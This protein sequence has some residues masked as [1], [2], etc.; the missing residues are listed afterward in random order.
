MLGKLSCAGTMAIL[1]VYLALTTHRSLA[2]D[3][4]QGR[5]IAE[6]RCAPCHIV[7]PHAR[8]E[9]ANS[10]PFDVI[11]KKYGA[12][13]DMIAHAILTPHTRMNLALSPAEAADLAAYIASLG[14]S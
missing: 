2:A 5:Q 6:A 11:A 4:T 10:P 3:A 8:E 7:R 13:A 14:R 12:D 9:L 1:S